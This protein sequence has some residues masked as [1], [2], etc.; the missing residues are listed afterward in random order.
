MTSFDTTGA[1]SSATDSRLGWRACHRNRRSAPPGR[2]QAHQPRR[3]PRCRGGRP[4]L[5]DTCNL[6][7]GG[8]PVPIDSIGFF[9]GCRAFLDERRPLAGGGFHIFHAGSLIFGDSSRILAAVLPF[10]PPVVPICRRFSRFSRRSSHPFRLLAS[11][12]VRRAIRTVARDIARDC[13]PMTHA[14][15]AI[16][17]DRAHL[18]AGRI[19]IVL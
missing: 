4:I 5:R 18:R 19:K 3:E 9:A 10:L 1:A 15:S 12:I 14:G 7:P 16:Q 17:T 6:T 11:I 8:S 2:G 13:F